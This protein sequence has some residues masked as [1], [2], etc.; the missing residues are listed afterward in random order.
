MLPLWKTVYFYGFSQCTETLT[1]LPQCQEQKTNRSSD[2]P[3][4]KSGK[5]LHW[6]EID[7]SRKW[8]LTDVKSVLERESSQSSRLKVP[9][10]S[11]CVCVFVAVVF[12]VCVHTCVC[13]F[14][15]VCVCM[16]VK[17]NSWPF[18]QRINRSSVAAVT[19]E[20][21]DWLCPCLNHHP[22]SS[23]MSVHVRACVSGWTQAVCVC[24]CL[25]EYM[26]LC[27]RQAEDDKKDRRA[28]KKFQMKNLLKHC[29]Y[30]KA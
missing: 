15:C 16:C 29:H 5:L 8:G 30:F 24:V 1:G 27:R 11:D 22:S 23:A 14:V 7:W 2:R 20:I 17:A 19:G 18:S 28:I 25:C 6:Q 4:D 3:G 10:N 21:R 9:F 13:M 26:L 12:T